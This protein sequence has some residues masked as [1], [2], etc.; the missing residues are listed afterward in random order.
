M[1]LMKTTIKGFGYNLATFYCIYIDNKPLIYLYN[2]VDCKSYVIKNNKLLSD[3]NLLLF[4]F[5]INIYLNRLHDNLFKITDDNIYY[6]L[7]KIY[8]SKLKINTR[9]IGN[10]QP[11]ILEL[12]NNKNNNLSFN[13][14]CE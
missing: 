14:K 8:T 2:L 12:L 6:I 4:Y 3:N 13:Y 7:N 5:N 1:L 9:C 10:L 11:G